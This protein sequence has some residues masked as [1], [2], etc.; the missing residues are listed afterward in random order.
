MAFSAIPNLSRIR[1]KVAIMEVFVAVNALSKWLLFVSVFMAFFAA[2]LFMLTKE[3]KACFT[4]IKG[5]RGV[6]DIPTPNGMAFRT[7]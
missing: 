7:A 4:V 1:Q 3:W 6:I 2:N 5:L